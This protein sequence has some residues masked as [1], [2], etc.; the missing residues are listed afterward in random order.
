LSVNHPTTSSVFRVGSTILT[1]LLKQLQPEQPGVG[2]TK[3]QQMQHMEEKC[4]TMGA[5]NTIFEPV[6]RTGAYPHTLLTMIS[7]RDFIGI[8]PLTRRG[9]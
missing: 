1:H 6:F 7:A 2:P 5:L 4:I 8:T 3:I 9:R